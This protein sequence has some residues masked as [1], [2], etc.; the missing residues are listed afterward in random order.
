M[1]GFGKSKTE[2]LVLKIE[3]LMIT[4]ESA[5]DQGNYDVARLAVMEQERLWARLYP[6][7][8][9]SEEQIHE[10]LMKR[11]LVRGVRDEAYRDEIARALCVV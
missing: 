11:N 5:Y 3:R 9:W 8:E 6:I 7:S 4:M 10:F 2:K 1:F